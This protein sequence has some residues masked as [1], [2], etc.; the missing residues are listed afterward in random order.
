MSSLKKYPRSFHLPFSLGRGSDDKVL[1]SCDHLLGKNIVIT[2]KYDGGNGC[3]TN[4]DIFARSHSHTPTHPSFD[5]AKAL[6]SQIKYYIPENLAIFFENMFAT[7]SIHYTA[8]P[9]YI[10]IFNILDTDRNVWLSWKEVERVAETLN[11]PTVPVLFEGLVDSENELESICLFAMKE[12]EFGVDEREGVVVRL[13]DEF[14]DEDFSMSLGKFVRK[15]HVAEDAEH[16]A[17][18]EIVKNGLKK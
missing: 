12:K 15:G 17:H 16:W 5:F 1:D 9:H 18:K 13:V 3:Y 6:H 14:R 7:H 4:K 10:N 2:S 11:I 8:L